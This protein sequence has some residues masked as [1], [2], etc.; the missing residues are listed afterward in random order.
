MSHVINYHG[1]EISMDEIAA[2]CHR[3]KLA[4]IDVLITFA[5]DASRRFYDLVIMRDELEKMFGRSVDLVEKRLVESSENSIRRRHV[6]NH[7]ETIFV[8]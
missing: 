1:L 5:P 7:M 8:A 3:W 4:D 2:F 6:S